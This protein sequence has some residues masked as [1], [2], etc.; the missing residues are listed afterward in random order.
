MPIHN[1]SATLHVSFNTILVNHWNV[2]LV[3]IALATAEEFSFDLDFGTARGKENVQN[4]VALSLVGQHRETATGL[5]I[6]S[7]NVVF[8]PFVPME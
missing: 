6:L 2:F 7:F 5:V 4:S 3:D 8:A 1:L